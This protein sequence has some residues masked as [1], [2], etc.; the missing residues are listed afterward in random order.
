MR[1]RLGRQEYKNFYKRTW[2]VIIIL[3]IIEVKLN[4]NFLRRILLNSLKMTTDFF[5]NV[6]ILCWIIKRFVRVNLAEEEECKKRVIEI[7]K[8][9]AKQD[10][11]EFLNCSLVFHVQFSSP[12]KELIMTGGVLRD[13]D[14]FFFEHG[15]PDIISISDVE[16]VDKRRHVDD[17]RFLFHAHFYNKSLLTRNVLQ[18][19]RTDLSSFNLKKSKIFRF[20]SVVKLNDTNINPKYLTKFE[21]LEVFHLTFSGI[22]ELPKN[23]LQGSEKSLQEINLAGNPLYFLAGF[24][25]SKFINLKKFILSE[26]NNF[27]FAVLQ[28]TGSLSSHVLRSTVPEGCK[29]CKQIAAITKYRIF[30]TRSTTAAAQPRTSTTTTATSTTADSVATIASTTTSLNEFV[31]YGTTSTRKITTT[32]SNFTTTSQIDSTNTTS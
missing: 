9:A 12:F 29:Q 2:D 11:V 10:V 30:K 1:L 27:L 6:L 5:L 8:S 28:S 15:V 13:F 17:D 31:T 19:S 23:F 21:R 25:F 14:Q 4:P 24:N 7:K 20:F 3:V 22:N 18:V 26:E 16:V 32:T